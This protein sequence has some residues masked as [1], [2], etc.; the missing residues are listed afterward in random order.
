MLNKAGCQTIRTRSRFGCKS[1]VGALEHHISEVIEIEEVVC[2]DEDEPVTDIEIHV[3]NDP[4]A[5]AQ[6]VAIRLRWRGCYA[7]VL[8]EDDP[9]AAEHLGVCVKTP[10]L[11]GG[12]LTFQEV[13]HPGD[14]GR[15][16]S[17]SS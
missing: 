10:A 8:D 16:G 7:R 2:E 5:A 6:R 9:E 14:A 1:L 13:Q 15:R 3:E 4:R 11:V 17:R 12:L